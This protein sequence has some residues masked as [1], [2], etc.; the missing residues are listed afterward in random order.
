MSISVAI[1]GGGLIGLASA[2]RLAAAGARVAVVDP[3]P[4]SGAS[5]VAAGMLAPVTEVTYGEQDRLDLNIAAA[6]RWPDFA[7][8]LTSTTGADLGYRATGTLLV[9]FDDDDAAA[10]ADLRTFQEELGL[11]VEPLRGRELRRREP[12]LHPRVRVGL[13]TTEDHRVDPRLVIPALR[14]ACDHLDVEVVRQRA[15]ALE[16]DGDRATGLTLEDGTH[17]AADHV[18]LA[19]GAWSGRLHG[20][21]PEA[22]PAVR[23]VKGQLLHLRDP[24]GQPVLTTT[25]RGLVRRRSIY[26]VPRDDGGLIIGASEEERGFDTTVTAGTVRELLDDAVAIV[27]GIDELELIE[28]IAGLRPTTPDNA[29][30]IGPTGVPG[31]TVATG[32]HRNGVLLTAITA[33][34][35]L[36]CVTGHAMPPALAVADP[37]RPAVVDRG[38]DPAPS[39]DAANGDPVRSQP[40]DP[41]RSHPTDPVRGGP[42]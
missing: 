22:R 36:A 40:T 7:E 4:G 16:R 37:G 29:P 17:L 18:V 23:P 2:W 30:V 13:A 25:V 14:T 1:V 9:G 8:E 34:A 21:P 32:H 6:R 33:D 15:T 31:L 26:L 39:W 20:L 12:M 11:E 28:T 10:L 5:N 24:S 42:T 19:A 27:P 38:A 35:V 41:V 3:D